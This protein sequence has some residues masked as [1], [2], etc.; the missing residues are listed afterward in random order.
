LTYISFA[1]Q[2]TIQ[3]Q[4]T[5]DLKS[6]AKLIC[7][8]RCLDSQKN[9]STITKSTRVKYTM[10][11]GG[12]GGGGG[13]AYANRNGRHD[14]DDR[15]ADNGGYHGYNNHSNDSNGGG[16]RRN[17]G[18][19]YNNSPSGASGAGGGYGS[20]R[21]GANWGQFNGSTGNGR[22][23]NDSSQYP[24]RSSNMASGGSIHGGSPPN[25]HGY[26]GHGRGE[27]RNSFGDS[28]YKGH[29]NN[30]N[31]ASNPSESLK[32]YQ[33][34]KSSDPYAVGLRSSAAFFHETYDKLERPGGFAD[35][36]CS[37]SVLSFLHYLAEI[38]CLN[39]QAWPNSIRKLVLMPS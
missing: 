34:S 32:A 15:H 7:D 39:R 28:S 31:D 8:H 9:S 13:V 27:H 16:Y 18:P 21:S 23:R 17:T 6:I 22:S 3:P 26:D 37:F 35:V 10:D 20:G 14:Y 11:R 30:G 19:G 2:S 24:D 4:A 5:L 36:S 33:Q 12:G 25:S 1:P 29:G 38:F